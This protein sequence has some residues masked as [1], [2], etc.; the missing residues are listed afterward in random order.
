[1]S[2]S[3]LVRGLALGMLI[4]GCSAESGSGASVGAAGEA[5]NGGSA[6][7]SGDGGGVVGGFPAGSG[8][9]FAG[10]GLGPGG[11]GGG[12][13]GVNSGGSGGGLGDSPAIPVTWKGLA[14]SADS[15]V[16]INVPAVAS[17]GKDGAVAY[18]ERTTGRVM[19]QRFDATGERLGSAVQLASDA[20]E[21]SNVTLASDG[22]QYVGCWNVA[23][24][25]HCSRV[26]EQGEVHLN[27]LAVS[28][29]NAT[30]VASAAGW[31]LAYIG[32]DK[33]LFMQPLNA[34]LDSTGKFIPTQWFAQS[35]TQSA[36]P[37][38]VATTS[39]YVLVCANEEG[40]DVDLVRLSSD[41]KSTISTTALGH[42]LWFA[43]QLVATD[44]R[45]AVS[46]S[47]PYG[48]FLQLLD[49]KNLTA[50][51][52]IAGG[53]KAGTNQALVL[54]E[55]GIGAA[56]L[57]GSGAVHQRWFADGHDSAVGLDPRTPSSAALGL[58]EEGTDS[59]QQLVQVGSQTVLVAKTTSY[60]PLGTMRAAAVSFG[61]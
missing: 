39:G 46:L 32:A 3:F 14:E 13:A 21:R 58:A 27:A 47:I 18:V 15:D 26:D 37:L 53:G 20:V 8:A 19:M 55:G 5:A 7:T 33:H 28:G 54:I 24:E 48:S 57:D 23:T 51:L 40:A 16:S 6:G 1:M 61:E 11:A 35:G 30:I 56:W 49:D 45:A 10:A 43:A 50:E 29:Q 25:V 41:L 34:T 12:D 36:G 52:P 22:K 4:C 31:V 42:K 17:R 60:G 9:G 59:Y 44:T 38:F 2:S